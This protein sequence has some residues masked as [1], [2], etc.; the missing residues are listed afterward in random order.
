MTF[1]LMFTPCENQKAGG[2][3]E[4][5]KDGTK[6]NKHN[7]LWKRYNYKIY[8]QASLSLSHNVDFIQ[9]PS[10]LLAPS[11][12]TFD[13]FLELFHTPLSHSSSSVPGPLLSSSHCLLASCVLFQASDPLLPE[14]FQYHDSETS[15]CS[16]PNFP[17]CFRYLSQYLSLPSL[18]QTL[19]AIAK[20]V[21]LPLVL[22][23][24]I[25]SPLSPQDDLIKI[26][27]SVA[28]L[29]PRDKF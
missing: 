6:T 14:C 9:G 29:L 7:L 5:H 15:M 13:Y 12:D 19:A 3:G 1:P 17:S 20:L 8:Q 11:K 24:P 2:G 27:Y 18:I 21:S 10:R 23:Y 26:C 25:H 16:K 4:W 22:L 28:F